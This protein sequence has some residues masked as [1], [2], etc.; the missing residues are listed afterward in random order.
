MHLHKAA[1]TYKLPPQPRTFKHSGSLKL[2]AED[3]FRRSRRAVPAR[4]AYSAHGCD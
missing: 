1:G 2:P 3:S 4:S